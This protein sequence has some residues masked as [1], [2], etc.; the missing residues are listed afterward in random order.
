MI[1]SNTFNN[2][3]KNENG[4]LSEGLVGTFTFKIGGICAICHILGK[5]LAFIQLLMIFLICD[6]MYS[7][8]SFSYFTG[9]VS[10]T[11][12][13]SLFKL[14]ISFFTASYVVGLRVNM[15]RFS[16]I[17]GGTLLSVVDVK[18]VRLAANDL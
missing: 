12:E 11:V 16:F 2:S 10:K 15:S 8:T 18:L 1:L 9:I 13:Q 3:E 7:E 6:G 5:L 17:F 14:L 4:L